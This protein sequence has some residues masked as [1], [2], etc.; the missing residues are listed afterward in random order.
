MDF[1]Y[2]DDLFTLTAYLIVTPRTLQHINA[3]YKQKVTLLDV[4]NLICKYTH[5]LNPKIVIK[6][7]TMG[8]SYSGWWVPFNNLELITI[9][10]EEGIRR[11]I[12][13]LL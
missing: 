10:L 12:N 5:Y 8:M 11:T 9:G 7:E 13:K 6:D 4:A 2:M 1:I 3:S